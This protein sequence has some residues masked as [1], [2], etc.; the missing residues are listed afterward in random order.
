M[1]LPGSE[2]FA[3]PGTPVRSD[4]A[5]QSMTR[6]YIPGYTGYGYPEQ[7]Y[8]TST[9]HDSS[10]MQGVELQY[11]PANYG[12]RQPVG[13]PSAQQYAHYQQGAVMQSTPQQGMYDSI[14]PFQQSRQSAA[15]EVMSSQLGAM[16]HYMQSADQSGMQMQASA[17]NYTSRPDQQYASGSV[18]RPTIPSQYGAPTGEYP[19]MEQQAPQQPPQ[20]SAAEQEALQEGLREYES[21]LTA[22]FEAIIAGRVTEASEKILPLS[23]WLTS[24]IVALGLHHDDSEKYQERLDMWQRF[25]LCWEALGQKQKDIYDEAVHTNRQPNDI[26]SADVLTR[27][28]QE[29]VN[30]CDQL[31]QYGLV[32]YELGIAE[33]Q[34]V[35]IFIICLDQ[36]QPVSTTGSKS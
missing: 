24:N 15:I 26:L 19:M 20:P 9:I 33:E 17:P 30:M 29:L 6:S 3:Q 31:E 12:V 5:R 2:R 32:D 18:A 14:P 16:P 27:L 7:Q 8:G 4:S 28:V 35:H 23:R 1:V 22:T 36:I 21:Q 13:Q 10:P 11:S 34:I 25:N